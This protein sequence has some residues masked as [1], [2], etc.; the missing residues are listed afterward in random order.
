MASYAFPESYVEP[1]LRVLAE[2]HLL[3]GPVRGPDGV[4]RLQPVSRL[5]DLSV[6]TFPLIPLKKFVLPARDLLWSQGAKGWR[7]PARPPATALVGIPPCD[8]AA[9][10]YLDRVFADDSCYRRRRE[11][12]VLFG[13]NC[14][15][16]DRCF[17]PPRSR[18][19]SYDLF[20]AEERLWSGSP[21]GEELLER[22]GLEPEA[23][24]APPP[25]N[26]LMGRGPAVPAELERLFRASEGAGFWKEV[27]SRCLSCGA[28][29]AVC[30]TCYCYDLV[31][32]ARP[33]DLIARRRE[34]D[35][36][37]FRSHGLVAGGHNFRHKRKDRLRF[38]FEHKY[39]GFGDLRGESSCVG[40]GRCARACP[41]EI[42]IAE[43]LQT[44]T[45]GAGQ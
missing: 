30:P 11:A 34:W 1:L 10:D 5:A 9:L 41:V 45:A 7:R 19:P 14:A 43:V 42:D 29:S 8:L 25:E 3:F 18:P 15:P 27:G 20:L 13:M 16:N 40:C 36:C 32:E 17:C 35:N 24:Q 44:L 28:C 37:F 31:D 39:L 22:F 6:S 4:G 33:G 26:L 38:R 21:R 2:D 12:L 23:E